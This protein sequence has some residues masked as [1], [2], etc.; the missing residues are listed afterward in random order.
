MTQALLLMDVQNGIVDRFGA[1]DGY[2]DRVVAAQERAEAAGLL[3]VL[4]RVGFAPGSPEV[5]ARNKG[6]SAA[7]GRPEMFLGQPGVEPHARLLRDNGEV[8]VTK[9]RVSAFAGSDLELVLRARDVTGLVLGGIA[10][11]G[12]VLSTVREAADRDYELTVLE[13][14]CLDGDEEVHRVLT[15]K[16]FPR[17]ADVIAS[18]DWRP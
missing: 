9:K 7:R 14:L 18:A 2:L 5:S 4:V 17:Q 13:D 16:V 6:F 3:V 1:D 15:Q 8:V 12:V 10:T 11:S